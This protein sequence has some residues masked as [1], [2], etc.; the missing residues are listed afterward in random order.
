MDMLRDELERAIPQVDADDHDLHAL[1]GAGRQALRR[2]R[3]RVSGTLAAGGLVVAGLALGATGVLSQGVP[4]PGGDRAVATG[5]SNAEASASPAAEPATV[6]L[7]LASLQQV[8]DT[9]GEVTLDPAT[10]TLSNGDRRL[11]RAGQVEG[12]GWVAVEFA[13]G[14]DIVRIMQFPDGGLVGRYD[15]GEGGTLAEWAEANHGGPRR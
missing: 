14:A 12:D 1:I 7:S 6:A 9:C 13:C 2:R 5:R 11:S 15:A 4:E 10:R 8:A 3:A